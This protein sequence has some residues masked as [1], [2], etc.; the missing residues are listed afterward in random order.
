MWGFW[1]TANPGTGM[2][3]L[4]SL[5]MIWLTFYWV[6]ERLLNWLRHLFCVSKTQGVFYTVPSLSVC[7]ILTIMG[8]FWGW[9]LSQPGLVGTQRGGAEMHLIQNESHFKQCPSNPWGWDFPSFLDVCPWSQGFGL[10]AGVAH[11]SDCNR[12]LLCHGEQKPSE[13]MQ[14]HVL[15]WH[16][17]SLCSC[18][19]MQTR[20]G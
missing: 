15:C 11:H 6:R 7:R 20:K 19:P 14:H 17:W 10:G 1:I 5:W 8:S 18:L 4:L 2:P 16:P 13:L 9:E 3:N 12:L